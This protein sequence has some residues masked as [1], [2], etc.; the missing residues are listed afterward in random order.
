MPRPGDITTQRVGYVDPGSR[1]TTLSAVPS[2]HVTLSADD[3]AIVHALERGLA[4][5]RAQIAHPS[6]S[7]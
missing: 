2:V 6:Y 7:N 5:A 1:H 4:A 3:A